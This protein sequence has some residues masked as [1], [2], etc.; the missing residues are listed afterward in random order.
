LEPNPCARAAW[1]VPAIFHG[2]PWSSKV[3]LALAKGIHYAPQIL[4]R[5]CESND[6]SIF[7]FDAEE[8]AVAELIISNEIHWR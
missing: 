7:G 3:L 1:L 8:I 2:A 5:D 6:H 4:T